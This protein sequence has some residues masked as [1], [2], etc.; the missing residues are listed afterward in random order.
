MNSILKKKASIWCNRLSKLMKDNGYTQQTFLKEYK[1]KYDGGTQ[2]NVSRW[3]RVGNT[4]KKGDV[5]KTI[6]FPSY[7]NMVNIAEFFGVTIGYLTGETDYESFEM[8]KSCH[9]DVK[10]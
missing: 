9:F 2:A 7:E 3:L 1:D 10:H 6:G 8:E 5:V 4:I